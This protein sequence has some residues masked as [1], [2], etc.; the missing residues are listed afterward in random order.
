MIN[1]AAQQS[2]RK[3]CAYHALAKAM[4]ASISFIYLASVLDDDGCAGLAARRAHSLDLLHDGHAI[5]VHLAEHHVFAVEPLG[6]NSAQE[7]L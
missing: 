5:A 4:T 7:E 1:R 2:A 6:L 3:L